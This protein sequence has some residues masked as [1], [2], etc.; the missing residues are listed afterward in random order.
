[1]SDPLVCTA[2]GC[3]LLPTCGQTCNPAQGANACD[4][5]HVCRDKDGDGTST[6]ILNVCDSNPS[7]CQPGF[8]ATQNA[9]TVA[10]NG[11]QVCAS[12]GLASIVSYSVVLTNPLASVRTVTVTDN[13]PT[14]FQASYLVSNTISNGGVLS[15]TT[16]TWTN[17]SIAASGSLTLTYQIAWPQSVYNTAITN[18][19]I[20]MEAGVEAGRDDFTMTPFC[21]PGTALLSDTGDRILFAMVLIIIGMLMYRLK[22]HEQ[23]GELIWQSGGS[24]VAAKMPEVSRKVENS[25]KRDFEHQVEEKMLHSDSEKS[26]K[27]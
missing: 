2:N 14:N 27:N 26:K 10:K 18:T 3:Q 19:A 4:Q 22:L 24:K 21:T 1:V 9:L 25:K 8:C 15:G 17:L 12:T 20:V 11:T 23:I 7:L 13:L 5:N 6:C 16:I